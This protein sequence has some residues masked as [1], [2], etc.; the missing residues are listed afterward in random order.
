MAAQGEPATTS[1]LLN[2]GNPPNPIIA[3]SSVAT[4]IPVS[5]P[6]P[7]PCTVWPYTCSPTIP[8]GAVSSSAGAG[9][10]NVSSTVTG[11]PSGAN[12]QTGLPSKPPPKSNKTV[13]GPAAAGIAIA[14]L[15]IGAAIA[16][17]VFFLLARR[18]KRKQAASFQHHLPYNGNSPGPEK[19]AV[20]AASPMSGAVSSNVD[21]LLPPP[22]EDNAIKTEVSKVR[23]NIKNHVRSYYHLETVP[24]T[25]LKESHLVGLA[26][27]TG[28]SAS[29]LTGI[30]IDPSTRGDAIRLFIAW[31]AMSRCSGDR[32]PTLLPDELSSLATALPG[33]NGAN[34]AQAA[35][36]SKWKTITGALLNQRYG[37]QVQNAPVPSRSVAEAIAELNTFLA[38][39][40]VGS[41][42]GG[43]RHRNLEMIMSRSAQLAFLLF[44]QPGSFHFDFTGQNGAMVVF[45]ALL[46]VVGDQAETLSP[47]KI[48][49]PKEFA[50]EGGL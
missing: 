26:T 35:L 21:N 30:F 24:A 20:V 19:G 9:N 3:T 13:T 29:A 31:V 18:S 47:P 44:S 32:Q 36:F 37:K 15:I 42:D 33:N 38:P 6:T 25:Q 39:F 46:Q 28:M 23:D 8:N 4:V 10:N 50:A 5:V 12:S 48:L 49:W 27:A 7:N 16:A 1:T 41:V 11:V 2:A 22:A 40:V 17:I 34:A 43:Q 14:C 45:P